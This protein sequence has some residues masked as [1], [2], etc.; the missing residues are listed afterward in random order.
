MGGALV[1]SL[2]ED[3]VLGLD[4]EVAQWAPE[5]GSPS[6]LRRSER[7]AGRRGAG[8]AAVTIRH[9]LTLTSGWGVGLEESPLHAAMIE[10]GVF[11]S[12]MG[13]TI[14]GDEFLARVGSLPLAFQPGEGWRYETSF[15]LL[16]LVL[17][18]ALGRSLGALLAERMLRAAGDGRHGVLGRPGAAGGGVPADRRR[19]GADRPAGREVRA[20]AR[21]RAAQRRTRLDAPATCCASTAAIADGELLSDASRAAMTSN[22]LTARSARPRRSAFLP[23][24]STWGLGT[25]VIEATG[26]W[27]WTGGSGTTAA[28][29][30]SRDTVAVL[31]TQ[32]AMAGPD[33]ARSRSTTPS[34]QRPLS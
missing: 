10:R 1:L 7:A 22:A 33:D 2:V 3:G 23:P 13:H 12:A 20:P 24:G 21:V 25:G 29:D 28:V 18:R 16:G 31:L 8:R 34:R 26:A 19:P 27:G 14:T 15:N 9:L 30:P 17:E 5:L 32:R 6:V 11:A 4:D